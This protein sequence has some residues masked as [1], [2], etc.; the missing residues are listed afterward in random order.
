MLEHE[1]VL[2]TNVQ[3]TSLWVD[4]VFEDEIDYS[5]FLYDSKQYSDEYVKSLLDKEIRLKHIV[6]NSIVKP[7]YIKRNGR[8][9]SVQLDTL[10]EDI[11]NDG[12]IKKSE[13]TEICLNGIYIKSYLKKYGIET[14]IMS[15]V[16]LDEEFKDELLQLSDKVKA[17]GIS[18]TFIVDWDDLRNVA[19]FIRKY[20]PE[21][22]I[23]VGGPL[24]FLLRSLEE[25]DRINILSS[26]SGCVDYVIIEQNGEITLKHILNAVIKK[27]GVANIPNIA[28]INDGEVTVNKYE[29]EL[30]T[31]EENVIHWDEMDLPEYVNTVP[32]ETSRGCPFKCNFCSYTQFHRY[33]LKPLDVLRKELISLKKCNNIK[34]I[35]FVDGSLNAI[36][37]RIESICK[38]LIEEKIN[39]KWHF[40]GNVKGLS[41]KQAAL[42]AAS[43]CEIANIGVESGSDFIRRKMNKPIESNYEVAAAFHNLSN[44]GIIGRGYFFVGYPGESYETINDTIEI[45]NST[46]MNLFRL[47]IFRPRVNSAVCLNEPLLKNGLVGKGYLWSHNSCD[48]LKASEYLLE[49]IRKTKP[50]YDPDRGVYELMQRGISKT[51]ALRLN[52]LKNQMAKNVLEGYD[53]RS[54]RNVEKSF[55][56]LLSSIKQKRIKEIDCLG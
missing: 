37:E 12:E 16:K 25:R 53:D 30:G 46:E 45:I 34:Y 36:P 47:A 19:L 6:Q 51:D 44:A 55:L 43:G 21:I 10:V 15:D 40:M 50:A 28:V 8:N 42:M 41:A 38:I 31:F 11:C 48:S 1:F 35:S 39:I 23:I 29:E 27:N 54:Y 22:K 26:L 18:T 14:K 52:T 56:S 24:A 33:K 49:I 7:N 13:N 4:G 5:T 17:V 20:L 9:F 3:D 32:I 2:I